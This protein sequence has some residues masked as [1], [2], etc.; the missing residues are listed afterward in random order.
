MNR[1]TFNKA[2]VPGLFS[3]AVDSYER[4]SKESIWKKLCTVKT[5]NRAYEESAY[6]GGLGFPVQKPEGKEI[7]Y[8]DLVQGPTK[9]WS[10]KTYGLA[11]R[12]TE[13]LIE[14]SLY[15]DVPTEMGSMTR[16]IGDSFAELFEVLVHDIINS[17][18]S[19]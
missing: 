10:H 4:K 5:S 11:T 8:D 16:E 1:S 17:G 6:F 7:T 12:I 19:T 14:D 9:R 15:P 13:E 2:I 18:T 3:L